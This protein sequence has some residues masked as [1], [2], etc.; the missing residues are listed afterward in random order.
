MILT[1]ILPDKTEVALDIADGTLVYDGQA[2]VEPAN[3]T[4]VGLYSVPVDAV[5]A[6]H[7]NVSGGAITTY[8]SYR[9]LVLSWDSETDLTTD[10]RVIVQIDPTGGECVCGITCTGTEIRYAQ[11][12]PTE[13]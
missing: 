3:A 8:Q 7:R 10:P 4:Y 13:A 5:S 11:V 6:E 1:A 9:C 12:Y 2:F